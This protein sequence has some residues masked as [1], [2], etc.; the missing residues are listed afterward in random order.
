MRNTF[1]I[2]IITGHGT[3]KITS[4]K[5]ELGWADSSSLFFYLSI[6]LFTRLGHCCS[7]PL[8]QPAFS[9][10]L[11]L[12]FLL[13]CVLVHAYLFHS[14]RMEGR[15]P[16]GWGGTDGITD[17]YAILYHIAVIKGRPDLAWLVGLIHIHISTAPQLHCGLRSWGIGQ[18]A[19]AHAHEPREGLV[20]LYS[21]VYL[22]MTASHVCLYVCGWLE[23]WGEG[24]GI[25][26]LH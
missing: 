26:V 24:K 14:P 13:L 8:D 22:L 4:L 25:S 16:V 9:C 18:D 3:F 23:S 17:H 19:H 21:S 15:L 11:Y 10:I 12:I 6:Y 1:I 7:Q 5:R 2:F 20:F